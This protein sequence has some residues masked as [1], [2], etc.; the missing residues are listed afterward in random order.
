LLQ[1]ERGQVSRAQGKRRAVALLKEPPRD[2]ERRGRYI[3]ETRSI[4]IK[5]GLSREQQRR[6]LLHELCHRVT[7]DEPGK[8]G[9]THGPAWRE[10]MRRLAREHGEHWAIEEAEAYGQGDEVD[11]ET[12]GADPA[13]PAGQ[14]AALKTPRARIIAALDARTSTIRATLRRV[15]RPCARVVPVW[16]GRPGVDQGT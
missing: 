2:S 16:T 10:E 12:S 13:E 15:T 4:A 9:L 8:T 11:E 1:N 14:D 5:A 6:V 7:E 3:W